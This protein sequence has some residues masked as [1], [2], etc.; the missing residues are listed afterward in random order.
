MNAATLDAIV[1][2]SHFVKDEVILG[3]DKAKKEL[4]ECLPL[5]R[6]QFVELAKDQKTDFIPGYDDK[7]P[8]VDMGVVE[9]A[10][11][12]M[13][14]QLVP[15]FAI[16]NTNSPNSEYMREFSITNSVRYDGQTEMNKKMVPHSSFKFKLMNHFY[17][18]WKNDDEVGFISF[19]V[20]FQLG[21]FLWMNSDKT[22]HIWAISLVAVGAC[23]FTYG[24]GVALWEPGITKTRTFRHKFSGII[25]K[26]IRDLV[27][28]EQK[29]FDIIYLVEESH[30]WKINDEVV[31]TP[32]NLDP[33]I[34]G[35]KNGTHFLL[36]K[37][38]V[39]PLENLIATEYSA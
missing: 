6:D 36:A 16:Y 13:N 20:I 17:R 2:N 32:K 31:E 33:L 38:D 12:K 1:D 30:S 9:N 4:Q 37:F 39:T 18:N 29:N 21:N 5:E 25:P 3:C 11:K 27:K 34:I 28:T 10:V 35:R 24:V 8:R 22:A 26:H 14:G 23:L 19:G 15:A 7:Y